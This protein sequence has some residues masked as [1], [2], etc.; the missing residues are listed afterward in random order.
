MGKDESLCCEISLSL[1]PSL[2]PQQEEKPDPGR[3]VTDQEKRYIQCMS[4]SQGAWRWVCQWV[5]F[6]RWPG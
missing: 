6:H 2:T 4:E 5:W 1:P 3:N